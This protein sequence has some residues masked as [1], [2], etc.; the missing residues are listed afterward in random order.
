MH[1]LILSRN[2]CSLKKTIESLDFFMYLT[3]SNGTYTEEMRHHR[4]RYKCTKTVELIFIQRYQ[5]D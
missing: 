5:N 2:N 4:A 3:I 1:F